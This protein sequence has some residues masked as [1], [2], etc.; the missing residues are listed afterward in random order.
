MLKSQ[1]SSKQATVISL[2]TG[3]RVIV[4]IIPPAIGLILGYFI[5]AIADWAAGLPWFPFQGPL[6]L[7]AFIQAKWVTIVTT[8]L[9]LIVGIWLASKAIHE[10]LVIS[11]SD[12]EVI[13][14]IG[15]SDQHYSKPDIASVFID[16][17]MLVLLGN[18][19]QELARE[20]YESTPRNIA[21]TFVKHDYPWA[22]DG[23]PY[24]AEYR[25]WVDHTPEL[26]PAVNALMR[27]RE[28][29]LLKKDMNSAKEMLREASKLGIM[30]RNKGKLQYWRSL[31]NVNG[32][33]H[34]ET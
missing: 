26:A 32:V 2:T 4:L 30:V 14:K 15:D 8:F 1:Q 24:E 11:V 6:K 9:G 5:P 29:A 12:D 22:S 16:D 21:D 17:K 27:Y 33:D 13:L 18:A 31:G 7:I 19:G 23:D 28:Q 20:P 25:L 3:E 34:D 10:S